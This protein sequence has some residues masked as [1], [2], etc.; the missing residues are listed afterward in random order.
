MRGS[1]RISLDG[2]RKMAD[3]SAG[4]RHGCGALVAL[5]ATAMPSAAAPQNT[6]MGISGGFQKICG[7]DLSWYPDDWVR[8]ELQFQHTDIE[9]LIPTGTAQI[10]QRFETIAGRVQFAF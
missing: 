5:F 9:K 7:G 6:P 3:R 8:L 4:R 10:G 1:A 2:G